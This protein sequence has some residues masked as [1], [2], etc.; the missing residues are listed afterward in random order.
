[1]AAVD[2]CLGLILE[3]MEAQGRRDQF[4]IV[5]LS[6]HGHSTVRAHKS[7]REFL[8]DARKDLGGHLPDLATASD[9]VYATPG[10]AEPTVE[11]LAPL[12][13]WLDAQ[14]WVDVIAGGTSGLAALPGVIPLRDLWNGQ[15][16]PRRPLLAVS[17]AWSDATNEFGV[18][19]TVTALTT[20]G[21][22]R[23]SHGSLSPYDMHATFFAN[24]PSFREGWRSEIPTGAI[25]LMPTILHLLGIEAPA[26][27]DGRVVREALAGAGGDMPEVRKRTLEPLQPGRVGRGVTLHDV[28][29]TQYVHGSM[30]GAG[31]PVRG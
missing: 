15:V 30:P 1:M 26:G 17:P 28:N 3:A 9:F 22:L 23:S 7:L 21:A 2:D 14:P 6:D 8:A 11:Q 24:G 10:T 5:F 25:D 13:Q 27:L 4:D 29:G 18:P 12:V 19:G 31:G 16:N 20:Q